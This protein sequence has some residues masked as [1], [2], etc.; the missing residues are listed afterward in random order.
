MLRAGQVAGA[1]RPGFVGVYQ[2]LHARGNGNPPLLPFLSPSLTLSPSALLTSTDPSLASSGRR[3]DPA[4]AHA[5]RHV[6]EPRLPRG[7]DLLRQHMG[8]GWTTSS[9]RSSTTRRSTRAS[10]ASSRTRGATG[11]ASAPARSWQRTRCRLGLRR[12]CGRLISMSCP[13]GRRMW[14]IRP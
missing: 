3:G 11:G 1:G 2:S 6:Q 8:A 7:H 5:N 13:G 10:S 14:M 9:A 12:W 4:H